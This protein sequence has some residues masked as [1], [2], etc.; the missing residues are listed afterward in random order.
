MLLLIDNYDSFTYNLAQAF[1]ELGQ[2]VVV[3]RNDA[4]TPE[5]VVAAAPDF[6]VISPGPGGPEAAGASPAI[7]RAAAGKMPILGV[8]LGHQV[9]GHVFGGKVVRAK[10][11]V[12]GKTAMVSHDGRTLFSG[13]ANPFPAARYHSL[14]V[15][16]FSLPPILEVSA[17]SADGEVM[18][19]RHASLRI[20]GVQFHPESFLTIPGRKILNNF[21]TGAVTAVGIVEAI[22][23][24]IN[25][26]DLSRAEARSVMAS[27]MEGEATPAQLSAFLIGIRAK[28]E[29]VEEMV[30]MVEAM[31]AK[32]VRVS[33]SHPHLV[34]TC[35]TGGDGRGTF[36]ISTAAAIVA[37]AAGAKVAKHG[38]R[39]ITSRSG[40]ADVLAALGV[41]TTLLPGEAAAAL[42]DHGFAFLFAPS[43][44][45][46]MRH[47]AGARREIGTRTVFNLLGP[48]TNPA[49]A[50]RQ[51][52][53][54][55]DPA[56]TEK[57]AKV[58]RE[59]GAERAMVVHGLDGTDEITLT[60]PTRITELREGNVATHYLNPAAFGL[61]PCRREELLGGDPRRNAAIIE[62][63]FGGAA[64]PH[65]D[66]VLLNA[67]A[68]LAVAGVA[69]DL[70]DGIA[71]AAVAIDSLAAATLL[72]ALRGTAR[73]EAAGA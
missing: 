40:S 54:V 33:F 72:A 55:F 32:G 46:A 17:R 4:I 53:G 45:P 31:R 1:E 68:A 60:A 15:E 65:R 8:C 63:V 52:V 71:R 47:A 50:K 57:V 59:L 5:G 30:G 56:A 11:P 70:R 19:V 2:E 10:V 58:L 12:H 49:G 69:D 37:A 35:G 43:Y 61:R 36:N 20:E 18:G 66:V 42:A 6:L 9:I 7:V 73:G 38:N 62:E 21:L 23:S 44:H 13:V 14:A 29:K 16:E 51:L 67:G 27:I 64:G 28:G 39:G 34:D 22:D 25:G 24:V 3:V 26:R 41:P 48:L